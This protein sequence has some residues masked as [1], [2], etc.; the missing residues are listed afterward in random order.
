MTKTK[1]TEQVDPNPAAARAWST[2]L[3]ILTR[4]DHSQ[5]E[6]RQRLIA[7]GFAA[8]QIDA[9]IGRCRKYGYLDDLRFA[10]NRA[11]ALMRQGRGVGPRILRDLKQ[12]G[13]SAEIAEQ[14]LTTARETCD[15]DTVLGE[16][17]ARKF[18]DFSYPSATAGE[19]RR[20]VHYLQRRGFTMSCIMDH[21]TR[22]GPATD[23]ENR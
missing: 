15:E 8:D 22:K 10:I 17:L 7:K 2:A 11:T 19:K 9:V 14:A 20:V 13:I 3:R 18:A 12:R 21:L 5:A 16:L 6:L 4:R 23:D 1:V